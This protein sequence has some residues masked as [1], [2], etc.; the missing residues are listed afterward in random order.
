MTGK[1]TSIYLSDEL[2]ALVATTIET[3]KADGVDLTRADLIRR[4]I[5]A[6]GTP[7]ATADAGIRYLEKVTRMLAQG[8]QL[9]PPGE[10]ENHEGV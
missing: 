7:E 5:E 10:K 9:V 4:G 1:Q 6:S 8:W 2:A 3:A